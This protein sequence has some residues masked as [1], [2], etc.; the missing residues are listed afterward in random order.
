MIQDIKLFHSKAVNIEDKILYLSAM[1]EYLKI[2]NKL[3][4]N[5]YEGSRQHFIDLIDIR[6]NLSNPIKNSLNETI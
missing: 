1:V 6:N 2:T 5:A 4:F 3:D